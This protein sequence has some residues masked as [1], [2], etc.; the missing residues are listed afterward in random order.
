MDQVK[1][2]KGYVLQILL[3]PL[4]NTLSPMYMFKALAI[5]TYWAKSG[6]L[7][8]TFLLENKKSFFFFLTLPLSDYHFVKISVFLHIR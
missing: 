3:G 2:F 1:F 7:T 6:T 8:N 4:S 5:L